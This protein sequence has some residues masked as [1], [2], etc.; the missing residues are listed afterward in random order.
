MLASKQERLKSHES[1]YYKF[2]EVFSAPVAGDIHPY[3]QTALEAAK[4]GDI[5]IS[6]PSQPK[7]SIIAFKIESLDKLIQALIARDLHLRI[8]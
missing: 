8:H 3:L 7:S 5:V 1:A 6:E 2:I 4:Y